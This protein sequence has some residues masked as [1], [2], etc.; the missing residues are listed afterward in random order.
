M[1]GNIQ[2]QIN[3]GVSCTTSTT[4]NGHMCQVLAHNPKF[5]VTKQNLLQILRDMCALSAMADHSGQQIGRSV[6]PQIQ[7]TSSCIWIGTGV[8]VPVFEFN[9][10]QLPITCSHTRCKCTPCCTKRACVAI[11]ATA[12]CIL[13]TLQARRQSTETC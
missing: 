6:G 8:Q 10:H 5:S 9:M 12:N 3:R 11:V 1:Y 13:C 2:Q 4:F 7:L